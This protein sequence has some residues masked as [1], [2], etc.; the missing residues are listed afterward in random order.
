LGVKKI[1]FKELYSEKLLGNKEDLE[2]KF[3]VIDFTVI[4]AFQIKFNLKSISVLN[5]NEIP[6]DKENKIDITK[7]DTF[8]KN[9][10][11]APSFDSTLFHIEI[12]ENYQYKSSNYIS[13]GKAPSIKKQNCIT[14]DLLVN[15]YQKIMND[16]KFHDK[17]VPKMILISNKP[18]YEF[19]NI[20][21]TTIS[22]YIPKNVMVICNNNFMDCIGK[23]FSNYNKLFIKQN[24]IV[25]CSCNDCTDKRCS[26]LNK[27]QTCNEDCNCFNNCKRKISL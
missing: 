18:F 26:C 7:G 10:P 19:E 4:E 13:N 1:N 6:V 12:T 24:N 2:T 22:N 9:I 14:N 5:N 20:N 15:E 16:K 3:E 27:N 17:R 11:L 21:E 8:V 23:P 25:C